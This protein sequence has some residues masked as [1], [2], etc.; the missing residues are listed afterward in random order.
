MTCMFKAMHY[1]QLMYLRTYKIRV[2]RYMNLILQSFFS[3]PGLAWEAALKNTKVKLD[4]KTDID[5]LLMVEKGIRV[6]I[7]Y[8]IYL[9][10]KANSKYM[11]DYDKNKELSYLQYQDINNL[12]GWAISQKLPGNNFEQIEDVSEFNEDFI[13][14]YN[15]GSDERYFLEVNN[16]Q[17]FERLREIHNDLPFS[18]ERTKI[19]NVEK[20]V[21]NLHDKTEY[22]M[23]IRYSKQALN[24]ELVLKKVPRMIKF[25]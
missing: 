14:N 4:L 1:C 10:P 7:C 11:N 18:P 23:H 21:A 8:S 19:E 12:Y 22:V 17:C 25:N 9:Y 6:G 2:L 13:K 16:I 3:A 20:L 15:E 5:M 24:H